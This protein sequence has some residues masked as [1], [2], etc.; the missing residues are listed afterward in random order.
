[1]FELLFGEQAEAARKI[2]P[3]RLLRWDAAFERWV[4]ASRQTNRPTNRYREG[5]RLLAWEEFLS[6][7]RKPP[8][9][10]QKSDVRLYMDWLTER[11]ITPATITQRLERLSSF[12]RFAHA[13]LGEDEPLFDPTAGIKRP[14]HWWRMEANYLSLEEMQALLKA[15]D[16]ETAVLGKRDYAWILAHLTSG[17]RGDEL[18]CLRW[19]DLEVDERSMQARARRLNPERPN[20]PVPMEVVEAI[21]DYL[22]AAGRLE[23][24]QAEMFI[25]APACNICSPAML[26][27]AEDWD[28]YRPISHKIM[29]LH[30]KRYASWAGLDDKRIDVNTLRNTAIMLRVEAGEGA[31]DIGDFFG[32][33]TTQ[34]A[35]TVINRLVRSVKRPLWRGRRPPA[36][37]PGIGMAPG[38]VTEEP[39]DDPIDPAIPANAEEQT[40]QGSTAL[41]QR[42]L[43]PA[44]KQ[45]ALK[46]GLYARALPE[47]EMALARQNR[48]E[49]IDDEID[50][51]RVV[52]MR[53]LQRA[54]NVEDAKDQM[55]LLEVFSTAAQRLSQ[56]LKTQR[57]LDGGQ[58]ELESLIQSISQDI[59]SEHG[60]PEAEG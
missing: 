3:E 13:E 29:L 4:A 41:H 16:R 48:Q 7:L 26:G 24:M 19:R 44:Q 46:H 50:A 39:A 32:L 57:D 10:A 49:G 25:F 12:Y 27:R 60:W 42:P 40:I 11:N 21:R 43:Y 30:L 36:G 18:N 1:M 9:E 28:P 17:L 56:M 34:Y 35:N 53:T 15:I 52:M 14:Y 6:L 55:R 31:A 45:P 54:T 23:T 58:S 47:S 38:E 59:L 20:A 37:K 8:W 5:G 2:A 33:A 51:L 22:K